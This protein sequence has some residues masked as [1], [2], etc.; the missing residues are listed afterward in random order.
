MSFGLLPTARDS[1]VY[2]PAED[3]FLLADALSADISAWRGP[4][5][6]LCVEIGSGSGYV[7]AAFARA[8]CARWG[9]PQCVCFA[10][11]ISARAAAATA[12]TAA[13]N[14]RCAALTEP[15]LCDF[16]SPLASRLRGCVDVLLFNPPYVPTTGA[17]Y[18]AAVAARGVAAAW[19]G[20]AK[21]TETLSRLLPQVPALLAPNGRFYVVAVAENGPSEI[22]ARLLEL[23]LAPKLLQTTH[24]GEEHLFVIRFT[25]R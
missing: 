15:L 12:A 6:R 9:A 5:P 25:H 14:G 4:P 3:T 10:T 17:E 23:G 11:D 16:A 8:V 18:A 7:S 20:G 22:A 2:E 1:E 19:A 21:G 13:L 24:A